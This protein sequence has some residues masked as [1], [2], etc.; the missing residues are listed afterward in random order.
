MILGSA[1][2]SLVVA[3]LFGRLVP[4]FVLPFLPYHSLN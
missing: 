3:K 2:L 4:K 1:V